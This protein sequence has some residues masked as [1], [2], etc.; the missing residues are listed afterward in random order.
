MKW[1][2]HYRVER[3]LDIRRSTRDH[4]SGAGHWVHPRQYGCHIVLLLFD[5]ILLYEFSVL[6]L[7]LADLKQNT[8]RKNITFTFF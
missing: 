6:L 2:L 4:S 3:R 5:S 8:L 7:L 1:H